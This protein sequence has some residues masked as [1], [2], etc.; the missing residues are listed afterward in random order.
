MALPASFDEFSE[1][2]LQEKIKEL[3]SDPDI[4]CTPYLYLITLAPEMNARIFDHM[5]HRYDGPFYINQ[6]NYPKWKDIKIPTYFGSRWNAWVIHL[7]G[8]P[9]GY[10]N[11]AAP[12]EQKKML[13]VPSDNYGGMDRP[14]H[15]IQDVIL[16]WYDHWLKDNDT[17]LM[18][19]P[20]ITLFIQGINKWRYENEWPLAVTQW[21]RFYLREDGKLS[22]NVPSTKEKPQVFTNNPWANPAQ[23]HA[24]ADTI[25][26]ADPFPKAVYE[27]EPLKENMEVTGPLALYWYA[28]IESKGIQARSWKGDPMTGLEV[29]EPLT[30]DT[31]WYLKVKDIDVDGAERC[32]AE[33]WLKAS[34]Y[35]IDESKSEPYN[36]YH[37][38]TRSLPI[39]P[40]EV[41]LY[42]S[43]L[44]LACNVFLTGHK[45]RLEIAGQDVQQALW[46]FLPHMAEV[47]HT[48][49]STSD[50]PSYLLLPVIPKNYTGAGEPEYPPVGPF[51]LPKY[52]RDV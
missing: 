38:H 34:R 44:K 15:E 9:D 45:I 26:K 23:G 8:A 27:T 49:Y 40:G 51:R 41:I 42:A 37:P 4:M 22:T 7:P 24:R 28:S 29:I 3:Q 20:P 17:G 36:P 39:E 33:G 16:R 12:K 50:K 1:Q 5:L 52:V 13:M 46:Y 31:D 14:F 47:T 43:D 35:E 25:A 2:D 19:E 21:T 30:N 18:A 32:V 10:M 6:A 11:V 48:I